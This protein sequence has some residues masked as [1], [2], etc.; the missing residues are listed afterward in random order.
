MKKLVLKVVLLGL[1]FGLIGTLASMLFGLSI[2]YALPV[3]IAE[4][5]P[6]FLPMLSRISLGVG[7]I[8]AVGWYLY[9]LLVTTKFFFRILEQITGKKEKK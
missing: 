9:V 1:L 4:R 3:D 6:E 2:Y 5:I 7:L 8:L